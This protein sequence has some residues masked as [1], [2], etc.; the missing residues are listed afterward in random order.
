MRKLALQY[1]I[2]LQSFPH[3]I[4]LYESNMLFIITILTLP[5]MVCVYSLLLT[6]ITLEPLTAF[7]TKIFVLWLLQYSSFFSHK[8]FYSTLFFTTSVG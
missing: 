4:P 3:L 8:S 7:I 5:Q 6:S 1:Q 2:K